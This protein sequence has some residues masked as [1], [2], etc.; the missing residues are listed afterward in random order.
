M[1]QCRA[2][3]PSFSLRSLLIFVSAASV[4]SFALG[5]PV[6]EVSILMMLAAATSIIALLVFGVWTRR[7]FPLLLACFLGGYLTIADGG[8][9]P[10]KERYLPTEWALARCCRGHTNL[11]NGRKRTVSLTKWISRLC[12]EPNHKDWDAV[13]T[14]K[15]SPTSGSATNRMAEV[16]TS[17]SD[18]SIELQL[19]RFAMTTVSSVK[20]V[21]TRAFPQNRGF[22][23]TGHCLVVV[24]ITMF[25][26]IGYRSSSAHR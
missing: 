24:S 14:L 9:F 3:I 17:Q 21:S 16:A 8:V 19:P 25:M 23:I 6:V 22:F 1:K 2:P 7:V 15:Y 20:T 13:T 10:E 5:N 18:A 12:L 4:A 11:E 26:V